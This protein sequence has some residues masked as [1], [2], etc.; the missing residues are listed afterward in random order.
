MKLK[1]SEI[2]FSLQGEGPLVGYPTFFIRFFGCNLD[3]SWCD[4]LYAKKHGTYYE[5]EIQE[6]IDL[7]KRN[8][9]EIPYIT[10]T[11]GEP[12]LQKGVFPLIESFLKEKAIICLE[13]NGSLSVKEISERVIKV[14]DFKTPSSGMENFNFYENLNFLDKKDALKFVIKDR[15]DFEWA[16][17]KIEEFELFEITQVFF[18][19]ATP[20]LSP[21]VLA[22]WILEVKK[23][24]RFQLQL[25]KILKLK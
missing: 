24:I 3:C 14:V 22:E 17:K 25:H 7:W 5:L 13:T 9:S 4:T 23:P 8:Y 2:F 6:I 1:I 18:S 19:P 16:L 21:Q 20:F 11:G 12:L 15:N 10:L